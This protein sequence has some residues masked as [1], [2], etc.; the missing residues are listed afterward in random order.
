MRTRRA[1]LQA[2]YGFDCTCAR[3]ERELA[4]PAPAP[5]T[6]PTPI[7]ARLSGGG[8]ELP[9]CVL[10]ESFLPALAERFSNAAHDGAYDAAVA[11]GDAL[12]ALYEVVYPPFYPL[13]GA[14]PPP[15]PAPTPSDVA[16]TALHLLELSKTAWNAALSS[17]TSDAERSLM[18]KTASCLARCRTILETIGVEG[19]A[20]HPLD[21]AEK[22]E[23]LLKNEVL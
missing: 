22:L 20:P 6:D 13:I 4:H 11:Y 15:P 18:R 9:G 7:Y 3:C 16:N 14:F 1:R 19:D 2:S 8:D 17:G 23:G 12:R 21:E 10:H 5:P